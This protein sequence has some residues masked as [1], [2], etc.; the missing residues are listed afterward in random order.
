MPR[1]PY[2]S[3]PMPNFSFERESG[4]DSPLAAEGSVRRQSGWRARIAAG[5]AALA[6]L[7]LTGWQV[8]GSYQQAIADMEVLSSALARGAEDHVAGVLGGIDLVLSEM[9]E[10][11]SP[12]GKVDPEVFRQLLSSR[13]KQVVAVRNA[14]ITDTNGR[15]VAST[16]PT[17]LGADVSDREYFSVTSRDMSR[18]L[19]ISPPLKSRF[20]NVTSFAVARAIRRSDG[21]LLGVAVVAMD[22]HL[23]DD[24]L[25]AAVPATGGR[26]TLI[27]DDGIVLAR[28][29]ASEGLGGASVADGGVFQAFATGNRAGVLHGRGKIAGDDRVA[30][31]RRL[32]SYPLVV[33]VG[34]ATQPALAPWRANALSH[35]SVALALALALMGFA[36]LSDRRQAERVRAQQVLAVSEARFRRLSE[37]SPVGI[38]QADSHGTCL[39]ANERW[40]EM[41]GRRRD[42]LLGRKWC[43]AV[44]DRDRGA[45]VAAWE[46]A[47][48]GGGEM[49]EEMRVE[50]PDG[51]VLW[52]RLR[53][54]SLGEAEGM[55]GLL[56]LIFEDI[57]AA[58]EARQ[59]LTLSEEK[60]AKAFLGSPDALVISTMET[61]SYVEVNNAFCHLLGY[62]RA[63][64]MGSDAHTL[65]VW[66]D[67]KERETL[68]A[69]VVADG[70]VENFEAALRRKD[71]T[72][73]IVQMSLQQIMVAGERCL[74]FIC[75][76]ISERREAEART[77]SL[78]ARLDA[79]NKELEQFAYVTSHDLQ[80]P[81]RMIA[82]YAQLLERRYHGRLDSDADDFI[83]FLVDGAKR[84]QGMILDLLDY[85]RVDRLGGAFV[86]FDG[87][88][89]LEEVEKNLSIALAEAGG[90]LSIGS[91]P[92]VTADR[93]QF[94]RLFQNLIGNA[95][96]YRYPDRVPKISVTAE[97]QGEFWLFSVADN[98]IGIGAQ[99]FDRIFLVFQR[100]HTRE[101]Y[102]GSGIGLAICKK[103]VER[104][105]GR[106]WVESEEGAG[107]TFHFTLPLHPS[108]PDGLA[109]DR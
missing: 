73:L 10:M 16:L 41:T 60:F 7:A 26:A 18:R 54:S 28:L 56:V 21:R 50:T 40:V 78:L 12:D 6:I 75:R 82:G 97:H 35:G 88:M 1:M 86:L 42:D 5:L 49:S 58:R 31:Y 91:I 51:K 15:I 59:A 38:V 69:K 36:T 103:I 20:L 67:P 9:S 17:S 34:L 55:A 33:A 2:A 98:G 62:S 53:A 63:E 76:D 39:Y 85:S 57:T 105:G 44:M 84:M 96:K 13:M 32:V 93:S 71:S 37:R 102:Q 43:D 90:Q 22:S 109:S 83:G 74:L 25:S 65:N 48:Q 80:E 101:H 68:V 66:V 47:I 92:S 95:L 107:S 99:Y 79:S 46:R 23:F 104:H 30:A 4:M 100:L 72:S 3:A 87:G 14:L 64:F 108:R 27:R 70:Q 81:L 29:P 106:I 77:Q 24:P 8:W 11:V 52:V 19:Y 61:G 94:V 45:V 89:A